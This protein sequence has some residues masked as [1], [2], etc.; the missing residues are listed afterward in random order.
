MFF[1]KDS[2]MKKITALLL[3]TAILAGCTGCGKKQKSLLGDYR[4]KDSVVH[5]DIGAQSE[6]RYA[7]LLS[8]FFICNVTH[9]MLT[10][11]YVF[12]EEKPDRK[13]CAFVINR[14]KNEL[15]FGYRM[16]ELFSPA[17]ITKLMTAL[18]TLNRCKTD[19]K[20]VITKEMAEFSRGSVEELNEGDIMTVHDLLLCMLV[21]SANNAAV[22]LA[23]HVAGSEA[24][25]VE[26][27]NQEMKK[28]GGL[29]TNFVNASGLHDDK[30]KTTP[31]DMYIVY[32]ECT[33]Y[34]EFR[35][36]MTY[37]EK[38]YNY[39]DKSGAQRSRTV[40]TTN[41]FKLTDPKHHYD[42]PNSIAILG[43][44]TGTTNS[45][46]YCL[47]MHIK[48]SYGTEYILGVFRAESEEKLYTK[49]N[50]LMSTYCLSE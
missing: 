11:D 23:I 34:K 25:F 1:R 32:Q 43:G 14:T 22:A 17:S 36:I 19:E 47:I 18:V 7:P 40:K 4:S 35:E 45:A 13:G 21:S 44:K 15:V 27:M 5:A 50:D 8:Q 3:V 2:T 10:T 31:Y 48:N 38:R 37:T 46:G 29:N 30:H 49:M 28:L 12:D 20:V 24:A 41:C 9:D 26:L 6:A 42:Y 39:V 33:K 16:D